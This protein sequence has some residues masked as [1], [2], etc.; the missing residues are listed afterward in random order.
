MRLRRVV[1]ARKPH[2]YLAIAPLRLGLPYPANDRHHSG[3]VFRT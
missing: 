3:K 2:R 1:R